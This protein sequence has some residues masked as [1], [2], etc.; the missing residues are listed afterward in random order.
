MVVV[1]M[2]IGLWVGKQ[3]GRQQDPWAL[4]LNSTQYVLEK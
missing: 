2:G 3:A 4:K 1:G